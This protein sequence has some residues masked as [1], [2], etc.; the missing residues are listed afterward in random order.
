MGCSCPTFRKGTSSGPRAADGVAELA[1]G[2]FSVGVANL[3][4][5]VFSNGTVGL[6]ARFNQFERI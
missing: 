3:A 4:A 5:G 1:A 2:I 6:V